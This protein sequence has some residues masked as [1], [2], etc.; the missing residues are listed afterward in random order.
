MNI[1]EYCKLEHDWKFAS[2][3]YCSYS[4]SKKGSRKNLIKNIETICKE[5]KRIFNQKPHQNLI[6]CSKECS[7]KNPNILI[8][9]EVKRGKTLENI[10]GDDKA[11]SI[12]QSKST[13]LKEFWNN[14]TSAERETISIQ[15]SKTAKSYGNGG[16]REKSG[17][18]K[19]GYF[20]GVYCQSTY[21]LV[22]VIYNLD[23]A[24]EFIRNKTAFVYE[25]EGKTRKY[26]PD[27]YLIK[28]QKYVEIKGRMTNND[29]AKLDQFPAE[30]I[31][32]MKSDMN[33]M[34]NYVYLKYGRNLIDLFESNQ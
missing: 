34:F 1:C 5:C 30:I 20:R 10:Y 13:A 12:K 22:W 31:L 29:H 26:Y 7:Y 24:V 6:Y 16:Y 25:F 3:K 2:G 21:E 32:L 15:R 11:A 28:D 19:K 4:C 14:L 27:F 23:H 17:N 18:S 33:E 9:N 8:H